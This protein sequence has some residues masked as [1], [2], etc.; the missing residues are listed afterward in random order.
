VIEYKYS[1]SEQVYSSNAG[2]Q[3]YNRDTV[4]HE[5]CRVKYITGV[6]V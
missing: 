1:T 2:V 4:V 5:Y 6:Q 3:E